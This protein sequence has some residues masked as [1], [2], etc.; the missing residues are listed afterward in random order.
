MS[1]QIPKTIGPYK[2]L[3]EL[4]R[5]N[6][7][8]VYKGI[9]EDRH[10]FVAVKF[11]KLLD[12]SV[13]A[14]SL[15]QRF[16]RE[17]ESMRRVQHENVVKIY[18]SGQLGSLS[19]LV[20]EY[21]EGMDLR[22]ILKREQRVEVQTVKDWLRQLASGL[23]A[24]HEQGFVHRD[25][26]PANIMVQNG[27]VKIADFGLVRDSQDMDLTATNTMVGTPAYMSP[28]QIRGQKDIDGRSD[29]FSLG[30][31]THELLSGRNPFESL[32]I[33]DTARAVCKREPKLLSSID[34]AIPESITRIVARC[35]EKDRDNRPRSASQLSAM[36]NEEESVA[37]GVVAGEVESESRLSLFLIIG[38]V[39]A[40]CVSFGWGVLNSIDS[41]SF[42]ERNNSNLA[43]ARSL[44]KEIEESKKNLEEGRQINSQLKVQIVDLEFARINGLIEECED[45]LKVSRSLG[46]RRRLAKNA[47]TL[48][49]ALERRLMAEN[50]NVGGHGRALGRT[51]F[52]LAK[53]YRTPEKCE[54]FDDESAS[55][56]FNKALHWLLVTAKTVETKA[57]WAKAK[58]FVIFAQGLDKGSV[59][60]PISSLPGLV[61]ALPTA[62]SSSLFREDRLRAL[63][64]AKS[65]TATK[66]HRLISEAYRDIRRRSEL[67]M[68]DVFFMAFAEKKY[69]KPFQGVKGLVL[70]W[71]LDPSGGESQE[72]A[73]ARCM[74]QV[75]AS[76]MTTNTAYD[77][78]LDKRLTH[79]NLAVRLYPNSLRSLIA[80]SDTI[81]LR[82]LGGRPLNSMRIAPLTGVIE[83]FGDILDH[84]P[85]GFIKM[86]DKDRVL[87]TFRPLMMLYQVGETSLAANY[88]NR[89][90][91]P[92]KRHVPNQIVDVIYAIKVLC[93]ISRRNTGL[94]TLSL[95]DNSKILNELRGRSR[96]QPLSFEIRLLSS[97]SRYKRNELSPEKYLAE[98]YQN[99][100]DLR[101]FRHVNLE[102]F[103]RLKILHFYN[104]WKGCKAIYKPENARRIEARS[105]LV[106]GLIQLKGDLTE[107]LSQS[108]V[109]RIKLQLNKKN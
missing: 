55:Y 8:V 91:G 75:I 1:S 28:E 74:I 42:E 86:T 95:F 79:A 46:A 60:W 2:L 82:A 93:D 44:K 85:P 12:E 71:S 24:I 70:D 17:S 89:Y 22:Q 52:E 57:L 21:I 10:E 59:D 64:F 109:D 11:F 49:K 103:A 13:Q 19:Y 16:F 33:P 98:I 101:R 97:I 90:L 25:L 77:R 5:G 50:K 78:S 36:L 107:P 58:L 61:S 27:Q 48:L 47:L 65:M 105:V 53:V 84:A 87:L 69:S 37:S 7:G 108:L 100:L 43:S 63:F 45:L 73:Y 38:L 106:T 23:N 81:C 4:G 30:I 35:L 68:Y 18:D 99:Y 20:L 102:Y 62:M 54:L 88:C 6:M 96:S 92:W 66:L 32:N 9:H 31:L 29:L 56:C 80:F 15:Q 51:Y 41:R 39:L 76:R 104:Y 83:R 72:S 67:T 14:K 40:F 34:P 94:A 26:K 3:G